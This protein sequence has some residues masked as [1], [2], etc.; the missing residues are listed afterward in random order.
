MSGFGPSWQLFV[1]PTCQISQGWMLWY[2][3]CCRN[4]TPSSQQIQAWQPT[5]NLHQGATSAHLAAATAL[6]TPPT[7]GFSTSEPSAKRRWEESTTASRPWTKVMVC[8]LFPQITPTP[9]V[10]VLLIHQPIAAIRW[11]V[12]CKGKSWSSFFSKTKDWR[13][14]WRANCSCS[15]SFSNWPPAATKKSTTS[16]VG[17]QIT[18]WPT[19]PPTSPCLVLKL[20]ANAGWKHSAA[21]LS[22]PHLTPTKPNLDLT[23]PYLYFVAPQKSLQNTKTHQNTSW[24]T[25]AFRPF[26]QRVQG[27]VGICEE[28]H[29]CFG[30]QNIPH[31][32]IHSCDGHRTIGHLS[33]GKPS[34]WIVPECQ[35]LMHSVFSR[36][37]ALFD[38]DVLHS[39][40]IFLW[41][42][43]TS[44]TTTEILWLALKYP[45][46]FNKIDLFYFPHQTNKKTPSHQ[47]W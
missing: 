20:E 7:M 27:L 5:R 25:M 37:Y 40:L 47:P 45:S 1:C 22:L 16:F 6:A 44:K 17:G 30:S 13:A 42:W 15:S 31:R 2:V 33:S 46:K 29:R 12:F 11:P 23:L 41:A 26:F 34:K 14:A 18:H 8:D 10:S 35:S 21:Q 32:F 36:S 3:S 39:K 19:D 43:N 4:M 38:V 24:L 28:S 9:S